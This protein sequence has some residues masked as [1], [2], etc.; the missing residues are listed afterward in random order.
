MQVSLRVS[1]GIV[2]LKQM[3]APTPKRYACSLR[4]FGV[5]DVRIG[6]VLRFIGASIS[7][8]MAVRRRYCT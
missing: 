3:L 7:N 4:Q 6:I 1:H 8:A 2:S 5:G